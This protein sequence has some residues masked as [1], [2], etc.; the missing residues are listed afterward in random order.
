MSDITLTAEKTSEAMV[1]SM[2]LTTETQELENPK[3]L[4][5]RSIFRITVTQDAYNISDVT[6]P[7]AAI[8]VRPTVTARFNN[9]DPIEM[10]GLDGNQ[11]FLSSQHYDPM[12][13]KGSRFFRGTKEWLSVSGWVDHDWNP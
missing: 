3:K 11:F 7:A 9:A 1:A 8:T 13:V 10:E 2:S 5:Y 6:T 4:Q 12:E